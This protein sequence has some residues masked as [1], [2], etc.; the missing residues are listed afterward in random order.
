[1]EGAAKAVRWPSFFASRKFLLSHTGKHAYIVPMSSDLVTGAPLVSISMTA[2]NSERWLARA[3]DS[4]LLQQ[5]DFPVEI[6]IG[7]TAPPM[8]P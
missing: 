5:T 7:V 2:F 1:M 8:G 6:V 4:V 3:L